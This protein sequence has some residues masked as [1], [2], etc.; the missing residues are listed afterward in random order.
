MSKGPTVYETNLNIAITADQKELI[1]DAATKLG[2]TLGVFTRTALL[3]E[4][5][6]ILKAA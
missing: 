2:F 3:K 5:K 4:A 6:K 1:R